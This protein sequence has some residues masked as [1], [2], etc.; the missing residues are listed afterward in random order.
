MSKA[1]GFEGKPFPSTPSDFHVTYWLLTA[2]PHFVQATRL[3]LDSLDHA[4]EATGSHTVTRH[5]GDFRPVS[6]MAVL[7]N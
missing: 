4:A 3:H 2:Y 1:I 7:E 6:K 5:N